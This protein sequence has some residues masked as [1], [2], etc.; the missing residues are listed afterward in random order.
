MVRALSYVLKRD[1]LDL[2]AWTPSIHI[3]NLGVLSSTALSKLF[4][5]HWHMIHQTFSLSFWLPFRFPFHLMAAWHSQELRINSG[6]LSQ[7]PK[8]TTKEQCLLR[9]SDTPDLLITFNSA[10]YILLQLLYLCPVNFTTKFRDDF[11][12]LKK[13]VWDRLEWLLKLFN[14]GDKTTFKFPTYDLRLFKQSATDIY[15]S[16]K[17][18]NMHYQK[19]KPNF[20][21]TPTLNKPLMQQ[22]KPFQSSNFA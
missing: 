19:A 6:T 1:T 7:P 3:Y 21:N 9:T 4:I 10:F 13:P 15:R 22:G 2:K 11:L 16:F 5:P 20:L 8:M 12:S 14:P 18:L 17:V